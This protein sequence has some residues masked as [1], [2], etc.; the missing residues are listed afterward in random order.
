[1]ATFSD[2]VFGANID[3][4]T[5]KK[6]NQLQGGFD[7]SA[8]I[9]SEA[10]KEGVHEY[11][12]NTTIFARMWAPVL[13][14]ELITGKKEP[15]QKIKCFII[16]DNRTNNY[17]PND[18]IDLTSNIIVES[19]SNDYLKPNSGITSISTRTEGSLGAI[20]R[21]DIEF[22]VHNKKDFDEIILP[23]FFKTSFNHSFRLR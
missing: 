2:R 18:V 9:L 15:N 8:N 10:D 7:L 11:T 3:S 16:N 13:E 1:M 20:L 21:T 23:F 17:E 5:L 6:I 14:E 12:G 4:D 19:T 22:I